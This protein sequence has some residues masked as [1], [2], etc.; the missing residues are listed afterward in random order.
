MPSFTGPK[1][2]AGLSPASLRSTEP[3]QPKA[4]TVSAQ[5]WVQKLYFFLLRSG[6]TVVRVGDTASGEIGLEGD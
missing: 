5:G 1:A 6:T 2:K 4:A 3:A